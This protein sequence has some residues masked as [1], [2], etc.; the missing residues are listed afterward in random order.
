[1]GELAHFPY[2][3]FDLGI[4]L[5]SAFMRPVW[6]GLHWLYMLI[7]WAKRKVLKVY[8]SNREIV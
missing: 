7:N 2:F 4:L 8:E 5:M 3:G 1:M 6:G